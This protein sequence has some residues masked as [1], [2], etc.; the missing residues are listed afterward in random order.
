MALPISRD[1]TYA[2]GVPVKS[3]DLNDFQD[4]IIGSKHPVRTLIVP[5][6]APTVALLNTQPATVSGVVV[7]ATATWMGQVSGLI[8]GTRIVAVRARVTDSA[9]GPTKLQ[10]VMN[11]ANGGAGPGTGGGPTGPS[12][13]TGALQ[14]LS[15]SGLS[16]VVASGFVYFPSV[17]IVSGSAACLVWQVE[18]DIDR[19]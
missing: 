5:V 8:V 11:V 1:T 19:L 10:L 9:S 13:G 15:L 17:S 16:I 18:I 12:A 3:V 14:T 6:S 4:C 7:S 2:P